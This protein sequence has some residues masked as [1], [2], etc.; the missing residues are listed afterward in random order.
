MKGKRANH[1]VSARHDNPFDDGI[2]RLRF[3]L[4]DRTGL[5]INLNDKKAREVAWAGHI[6]RVVVQPKSVTIQDDK[7][8]VYELGTRKKRKDLATLETSFS[9]IKTTLQMITLLAPQHPNDLTLWQRVGKPSS[10]HR[11]SQVVEL[12]LI[13]IPNHFPITHHI[14]DIKGTTV[15]R[16]SLVRP[17]DQYR[18]RN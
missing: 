12:F 2:I 3:Q 4:F 14:C 15:D 1:S 10:L 6:A 9:Q 5:K 7:T 17:I 13:G 11:W 16:S 8:G 18:E